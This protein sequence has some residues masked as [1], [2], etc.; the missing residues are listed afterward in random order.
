MPRTMQSISTPAWLA[1]YR[2]SIMLG[3]HEGVHLITIRAGRPARAWSASRTISSRIRGRRVTGATRS[4]RNR[5]WRERP[6]R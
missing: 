4:R 3:V 1:S 5:C 6:V 2:A